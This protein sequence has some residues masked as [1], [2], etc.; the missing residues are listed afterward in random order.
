MCIEKMKHGKRCK[1]ISTY[2]YSGKLTHCFNHKEKGM[3]DNFTKR[4]EIIDCM[5]FAKYGYEHKSHCL[6]HKKKDMNSFEK[7]VCREQYCQN[8][9]D[10]GL[11]F[12]KT[13]CFYHKTEDM[14]YSNKLLCLCGNISNYGYTNY[15][16]IRC[17]QHQEYGMRQ[18]LGNKC[19]LESCEKIAKYKEFH[20]R[21]MYC[22][23]HMLK[24]KLLFFRF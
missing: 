10:Y 22:F 1:N 16:P 17:S 9:A 4:C 19:C 23:K 5:L 21:K 20:K 6:K 13:H 7:P 24:S 2:G 8:I 12:H 18:I 14:L 15:E 11:N 3:I